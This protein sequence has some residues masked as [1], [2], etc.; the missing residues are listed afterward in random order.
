[1]ANEYVKQVMPG[2]IFAI[3][4]LIVTIGG[5]IFQPLVGHLLDLFSDKTIINNIHIYNLNDYKASMSI[6]P[7]SLIITIC[8]LIYM[9]FK[10][11]H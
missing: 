9:G 2:T 1:M 11:K 5:A 4:N 8:L 3:T 10:R 7:I 6:L